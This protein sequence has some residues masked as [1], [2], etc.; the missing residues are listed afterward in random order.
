MKIYIELE[1]INPRFIQ[2]AIMRLELHDDPCAEYQIQPG[3]Y[4]TAFDL[5]EASTKQ[6]AVLAYPITGS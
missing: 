3:L 1:D 2:A 4:A 5:V 6:Q